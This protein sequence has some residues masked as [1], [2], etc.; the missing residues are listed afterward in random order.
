MV[1]SHLVATDE[2][3]EHAALYCLGDF[4][5]ADRKRY[6][7]HLSSCVVCR[8]EVA[9]Y[10]ATMAELAFADSHDRPPKAR[11]DF[12]ARIHKDRAN[13]SQRTK[14]STVIITPELFARPA[15]TE[16]REG[17]SAALEK[18]AGNL[19]GSEQELLDALV[20]AALELCNAGTAGFS[21]LYE[22]EQIFR[23]DALAG[24]LSGARGG[25][26]PRTWSPCGT[27]LDLGTSQLFSHPSRCFEYFKNST[28]PIFEGLVAPVYVGQ[29]PIGT[30][31]VASHDSR[32]FDKGDLQALECFADFCGTALGKMRDRRLDQ[33][34]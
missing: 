11:R 23:W 27:T 10:A 6:E 20:R 29:K 2:I 12:L 30:L 9:A 17:V 26:T 8:A 31:W 32:K 19:P 24:E 28:P 4:P 5:A 22:D 1:D 3:A 16:S 14:L 13:G 33:S 25:T 21:V 34:L 18:L 15:R 7:D